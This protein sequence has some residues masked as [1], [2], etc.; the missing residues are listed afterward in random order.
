MKAYI[1]LAVMTLFAGCATHQRHR[2]TPWVTGLRPEKANYYRQL[3]AHPWPSVLKEI[4]ACHI[5]NFSIHEREID[6]KLYLFA[7]LEYTGSDF[8]ADSETYG[9]GPRNT[10]LVE[11]DRF[12][13]QSPLPEAAA[14]KKIWAD[15]KEIFY[16][17]VELLPC[18]KTKSF[19]SQAAPAGLAA[20]ARRLMLLK[21]Q[22]KVVIVA[23]TRR[24]LKATSAELGAPHLGI[25][26]DVTRDAEVKAAVEKSTTAFWQA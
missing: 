2:G 19:F 9:R 11:R 26:C 13:A 10:T 7:Y 12:P 21:E 4:K 8:D 17:A 22:A 5:Q 24:A 23:A 25:V 14:A 6:G 1:Y 20:T 3:H 16:L 18:S 15:T